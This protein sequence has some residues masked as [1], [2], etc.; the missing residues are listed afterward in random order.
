VC[1]CA[2]A[3]APSCGGGFAV[4]VSHIIGSIIQKHCQARPSARDGEC[5]GQACVV[6]L[7][8]SEHLTTDVVTFG[9]TAQWGTRIAGRVANDPRIGMRGGSLVRVDEAVKE[10]VAANDAAS[11]CENAVA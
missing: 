3:H 7:S 4:R 10:L 6:H 11:F 2:S 5:S 1:L 8:Q 9:L